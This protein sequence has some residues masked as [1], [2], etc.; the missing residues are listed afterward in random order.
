MASCT[1]D[2]LAVKIF[3]VK[4]AVYHYAFKSIEAGKPVLK[5]MTVKIIKMEAVMMN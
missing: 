2:F 5:I 1:F 3:D 4:V